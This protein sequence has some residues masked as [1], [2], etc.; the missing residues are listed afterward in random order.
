M[1]K[2]TLFEELVEIGNSIRAEYEQQGASW[3]SSPF[4]WLL[5]LPS[6]SVGAVGEKLVEALLVREGFVVKRPKRLSS[7]CRA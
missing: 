2:R 3:K 4:E 1:V 5:T 7:N 6:R